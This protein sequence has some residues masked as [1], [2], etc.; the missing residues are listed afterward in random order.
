[1]GHSLHNLCDLILI[2]FFIDKRIILCD[3]LL[4]LGPIL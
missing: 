1:M 3:L 4:I 2:F